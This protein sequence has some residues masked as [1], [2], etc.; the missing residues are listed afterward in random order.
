MTDVVTNDEG[1]HRAHWRIGEVVQASLLP[2]L[3][4]SPTRDGW[5]THGL[6]AVSCWLSSWAST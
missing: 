5:V 1:M 2:D 3:G 6:C 4:P